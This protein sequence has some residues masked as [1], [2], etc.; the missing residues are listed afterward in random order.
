MIKLIM[1]FCKLIE[2][3]LQNF[4]DVGDRE[5]LMQIE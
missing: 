5:F 3:K 2:M 1:L 4:C